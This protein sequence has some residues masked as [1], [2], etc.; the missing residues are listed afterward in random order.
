MLVCYFS[1]SEC[2]DNTVALFDFRENLDIFS[3][4]LINHFE[5]I[6]MEVHVDYCDR[7]NKPSKA[8]VLFVSAPPPSYVET[9]TF[10]NRNLQPNNLGNKRILPSVTKFSYLGRILNIGCRDNEDIAFRIIKAGNLFFLFFRSQ[11]MFV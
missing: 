10:N 11:K 4:L 3:P 8:V 1:N 6:G 2:L 5:E 9:T 7:E